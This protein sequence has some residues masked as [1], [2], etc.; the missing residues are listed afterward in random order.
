MTEPASHNPLPPKRNAQRWQFGLSALLGTLMILCIPFA[1]WGAV[2]RA[3]EADQFWLMTLCAAA[4]L[5]VMIL[6]AFSVSAGRLLRKR[7]RSSAVP[8][9]DETWA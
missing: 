9:D 7:R 6:V 2:L 3:N 8:L 5:G 1:L 4:P